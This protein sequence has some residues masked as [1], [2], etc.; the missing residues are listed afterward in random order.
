MTFSIRD[1]PHTTQ[2]SAPRDHTEVP[3]VEFDVV[4]DLPAGNVDSNGVVHLDGGVGVADGA[5]V[6]S[7]A[8]RDSFLAQR[9]SLHLSQLVLEESEREEREDSDTNLLLARAQCL[10]A[11]SYSSYSISTC[12]SKVR[13]NLRILWLRGPLHKRVVHV[14]WEMNSETY[15]L[16]T[17]NSNRLTHESMAMKLWSFTHWCRE[18]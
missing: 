9:H 18:F 6:V 4:R 2:I 10:Y 3:H 7:D 11:H 12:N 13:R 1:D 5:S 15:L 17:W 8:I 14:E 16:Q